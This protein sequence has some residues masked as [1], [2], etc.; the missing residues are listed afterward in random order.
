MAMPVILPQTNDCK[1]WVAGGDPTHLQ[2]PLPDGELSR[3]TGIN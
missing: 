3:L 2:R 1:Q